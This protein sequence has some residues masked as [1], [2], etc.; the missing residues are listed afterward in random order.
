MSEETRRD[1]WR[2]PIATLA[3]SL[4]KGNLIVVVG[5]GLSVPSALP[6]WDQLSRTMLDELEWESEA[7]HEGPFI[8]E[9]YEQQYGREKLVDLLARELSGATPSVAHELLAQLPVAEVYTTNYDSLIE[10]ALREASRDPL[11]VCDEDDFLGLSDASLSTPAVLKLMGGIERPESIVVTEADFARYTSTH[12]NLMEHVIHELKLRDTLFLGVSFK[13]PWLRYM[14]DKSRADLGGDG[15]PRYVVS[16]ERH[17]LAKAAYGNLGLD[18]IEVQDWGEVPEFLE[19]LR[20]RAAEVRTEKIG[21]GPAVIAEASERLLAEIRELA[22]SK[23]KSRLEEIANAA[24]TGLHSEARDQISQLLGEMTKPGPAKASDKTVASAHRVA[25]Q[26]ALVHRTSDRVAEAGDHVN[27]AEQLVPSSVGS[28]GHIQVK[29]ALSLAEGDV[30]VALEML[31]PLEDRE[32]LLTRFTA[33]VE[34]GDKDRCRQMLDSGRIDLSEADRDEGVARAATLYYGL[35]G[36][37]AEVR[38]SAESLLT[39]DRNGRNLQI[40]AMSLERAA[41]APYVALCEERGMPMG[42]PIFLDP[43]E[44][45]DEQLAR[46]A[47]HDLRDA[48][49]WYSARSATQEAARTAEDTVRLAVHL[50]LPE[51]AAEV[52]EVVTDDSWALA[53]AA[54]RW[55]DDERFSPYAFTAT[56]LRAALEAD[57]EDAGALLKVAFTLAQASAALPDIANLLWGYG[58]RFQDDVGI[59]LEWGRNLSQL[60]SVAQADGSPVVVDGEALT[61]FKVIATLR[62]PAEFAWYPAILECQACLNTTPRSDGALK[63]AQDAVGRAEELAQPDNPEVLLAAH[64]VAFHQEDHS[65]RLDKA[66]RL[67]E[68]MRTKETVTLLLDALLANGEWERFLQELDEALERQEREPDSLSTRNNRA[69][70][71]MRLGRE[72][73][74]IADL[75]WVFE[76][77]T[78]AEPEDGREAAGRAVHN[79]TAIYRERGDYRKAEE[80]LGEAH[81]KLGTDQ[82]DFLIAQ[83]QTL[84]DAGMADRAFSVLKQ[85]AQR[86][87]GNRAFDVQLQLV[88]FRSGNE[89]DPTAREAAARVYSHP[90]DEYMRK[91]AVPTDGSLGEFGELLKQQVESARMAERSYVNGMMPFVGLACSP[92]FRRPMCEMWWRLG[93]DGVS[94]YVALGNQT[95]EVSWLEDN[96]PSKAVLDYTTLLFLDELLPDEMG[97]S[98]EFIGRL[99]ETVYLPETLRV[100]LDREAA[101]LA[102]VVIQPS[103]VERAKELERRLSDSGK[104][105]EIAHTEGQP[106]PTGEVAARRYAAENSLVFVSAYGVH[107]PEVETQAASVRDLINHLRQIGVVERTVVSEITKRPLQDVPGLPPDWD[108]VQASR[109]IVMDEGALGIL[110]DIGALDSVLDWIEALHVPAVNVEDLKR[111]V[112]FADW[113]NTCRQ[114]FDD[115]RWELEHS[116]GLVQWVALTPEERELKNEEE[117]ESEF[118][119]AWDYF[120]D[121]FN[122]AMKTDAPVWT[123]DRATRAFTTEE[124]PVPCFGTDTFL[125]YAYRVDRLPEDQWEMLMG[126]LTRS[127]VLS[128]AIDPQYLSFLVRKRG[129]PL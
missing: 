120:F 16:R 89:G 117:I 45:V 1:Q 114:R 101:A 126:R 107:H 84:M 43:A 9:L 92:G 47:T 40:A 62:P 72:D 50:D 46:E 73:E 88:A 48:T 61:P 21:F 28:P 30:D 108:Q 20:D 95:P 91:V 51:L 49:L 103:R 74:A 38:S 76:H 82:P 124:E 94:R 85:E 93:R 57:V 5:A 41:V 65:A 25:A 4:A 90:D 17:G 37:V 53:L 59:R 97:R 11:V 23:W 111:M 109:E 115:L 100:L 31:E 79:L 123:D 80:L 70:A 33:C 26:L 87:A 44:L 122:V 81:V 67:V 83:A 112:E 32:A 56:R 6:T 10:A 99:F 69:I 18:V 8:A 35:L 14:R 2:A 116:E 52:L 60:C 27:R 129:E 64:H 86:F 63:R 102:S 15:R 54:H 78:E 127:R 7:D 113:V 118:G 58:E 13:D 96:L 121:L 42:V 29:A 19:L 12:P 128:L 66:S 36:E 125:A 24:N 39:H 71:L 110:R 119:V 106:D 75:H 34:V 3:H 98:L 77:A 104:V 55:P 105:Q 68:I 22:E